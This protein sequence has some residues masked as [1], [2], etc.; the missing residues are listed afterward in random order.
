MKINATFLIQIINFWAT[1]WV[2]S[3]IL[4]KPF[5]DFI[6]QKELSQQILHDALRKQ[7]SI[8][9]ELTI[10][11]QQNLEAFKQRI[12]TQY[13]LPK[14]DSLTLGISHIPDYKVE[15]I[16]TLTEKIKTVLVQAVNHGS[17]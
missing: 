3:R 10:Q 14:I 5:I 13:V 16:D 9:N 4:F 7:E 11:K 1:Y 8:V 2:L 12:S 15:N 17:R 6:A